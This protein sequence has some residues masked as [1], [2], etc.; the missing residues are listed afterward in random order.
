L[1][2]PKRRTIFWILFSVLSLLWI[3]MLS[4]ELWGQN[5]PEDVFAIVHVVI[6]RRLEHLAVDVEV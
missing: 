2:L 6:K 1:L 4:A 5:A 3:F